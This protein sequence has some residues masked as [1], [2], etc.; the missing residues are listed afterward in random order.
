MVYPQREIISEPFVDQLE[1]INKGLADL[2]NQPMN[3]YRK[4]YPVRKYGVYNYQQHQPGQ[5]GVQQVGIQQQ[6][7]TNQMGGVGQV[8]NVSQIP[9]MQPQPSIFSNQ[10]YGFDYK[11]IYGDETVG[12]QL[13]Q[14]V[15]QGVN[16][17]QGVTVNQSLNGSNGSLN[18]NNTGMAN[19]N[20]SNSNVVSNTTESYPVFDPFS[21]NYSGINLSNDLQSNLLNFKQTNNIWGNSNSTT[22]SDATVWG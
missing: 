22:V 20:G 10:P 15:S 19:N 5:I 6:I 9:V 18:G 14:G 11:S 1:V 17:N 16:V 7:T 3:Y 8:N 2:Q 4:K 21:S 13:N 12:G